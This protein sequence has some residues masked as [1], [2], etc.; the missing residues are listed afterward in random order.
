MRTIKFLLDEDVNPRLRKALKSYSV[1]LVVWRVGDAGAPSHGTLDPEILHWCESKGFCL[2][3]NNRT[4]MPVH[5]GDHIANGHH[6]PGIL[7][8]NPNRRIGETAEELALIWE[9]ARAD[10]FQ[11][12]FRYL[13]L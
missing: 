2:V 13:P 6:T 11:D 12:Q 3:T 4:T 8:F 1:E 5:L 10:E 7:I 9:L